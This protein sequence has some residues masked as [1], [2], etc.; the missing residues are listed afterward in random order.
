MSRFSEVFFFSF[1]FLFFLFSFFFK[2]K[3][4]KFIWSNKIKCS[5][6]LYLQKIVFSLENLFVRSSCVPLTRTFTVSLMQISASF[7]QLIY[8][9]HKLL[10][11]KGWCRY[12]IID[13][14]FQITLITSGKLLSRSLNRAL[15]LMNIITVCWSCLFIFQVE[16]NCLRKCIR[17]LDSFVQLISF[18]LS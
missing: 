2:K 16:I 1:F 13:I 11:E 8:T 15:W 14:N 4:R 5:W 6:V 9:E 12:I 10:S 7:I 17:I 3:S 18:H